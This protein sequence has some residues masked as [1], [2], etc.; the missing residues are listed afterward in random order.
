MTE[1][2]YLVP[3]QGLESAELDRRE[4]IA[5]ELIAADVTVIGA[6]DGALSIESEVEHEWCVRSLLSLLREN[7]D[8]YD[9]F[10]IGCFGDPGLAAARE[11]VDKP[12]IGPASAT[13]HTAAQLSDRFSCLT[14]RSTPAS[15]RRQIFA[16]QLDSRLASVRVVE[17]GV[18]DVDHD[19]A[20]TIQKMRREAEAAVEE[21]NAESVIPGCMSLA[22]MQVHD[23]IADDLGVPFLDP[24]RISLG[25]AAMWAD[26][27]L[28]HSQVTY[29][30]FSEE[31][32]ASLFE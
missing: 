12:V 31:R 5:N 7:R 32:E 3:G 23:R 14:V 11:F 10:V 1:I 8:R 28:C 22:F 30:A 27:E 16:D 21:D 9:G 25:T 18:L 29:P 4:R 15:K 19:S 13:F 24:V 26:Q 2:A 17:Q 20:E 6:D